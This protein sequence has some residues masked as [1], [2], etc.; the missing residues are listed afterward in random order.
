M[1]GVTG[2]MGDIAFSTFIV[3][4]AIALKNYLT[5][6]ISLTLGAGAVIWISGE[7]LYAY[8][9]AANQDDG[10]FGCIEKLS[11]TDLLIASAAVILQVV[12][13]AFL[14]VRLYRQMS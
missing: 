3:L 1:I 14:A 12:V 8:V 5:W 4:G 10:D 6:P 11:T 9:S 7:L 13:G 2:V